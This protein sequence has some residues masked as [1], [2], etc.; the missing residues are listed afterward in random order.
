MSAESEGRTAA[1][2]YRDRHH[3]GFQALG[4]LV[5]LIDLVEGIDVAVIRSPTYDAHGLTVRDPHTGTSMLIVVATPH[6]TRLRSTI[7]HELAHHV[8]D[9][10][11]DTNDDPAERTQEEMRADAFARHLLLPLEALPA[12]LGPPDPGRPISER[13]VSMVVQRFAISPQMV[14]IQ[15]RQARYISEQQK[16]EWMAL[17]APQLATR[18]GWSNQYAIWQA[19]AQA[20]RPPQRLLARANNGYTQGLV[21]VETIARLEDIDPGTAEHQLEEA[22]L[23]VAPP[24]V[25]R[26]QINDIAAPSAEALAA[27]EADFGDDPA[28]DSAAVSAA[29][30]A[31]RSEKGDAGLDA[32]E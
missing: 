5:A 25:E 13:D 15:L 19:D 16:S 29:A 31:D 27:F 6:A 17:T 3:L 10:A 2:R 23:V 12:L 30:S 14:A 20:V 28:A 22:G 32:D 8:F 11:A 21:S 18:F 4:D 9:D 7:A 26:V 24:S 1:Q